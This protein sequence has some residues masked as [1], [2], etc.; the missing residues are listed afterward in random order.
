VGIP[1]VRKK[2]KKGRQE[3]PGKSVLFIGSRMKKEKSIEQR[4]S[5]KQTPFSFQSVQ[6]RPQQEGLSGTG[7]RGRKTRKC[8]T[9]GVKE[10]GCASLT[11]RCAPGGEH[12]QGRR[13][14]K[15]ATRVENRAGHRKTIGIIEK[16]PELE[17]T[18][19]GGKSRAIF[20]ARG[21]GKT[22]AVDGAC[23]SR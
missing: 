22:V 6:F 19:T 13:M 23:A 10:R 18:K 9:A 21:K 17:R 12:G 8:T 15:K 7:F 14:G 3:A 11:Q 2:C 5:A 4:Y 1:K 20:F 16:G